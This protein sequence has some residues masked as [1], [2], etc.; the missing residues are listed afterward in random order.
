L[1]LPLAL[2]LV[3]QRQEIRKK[4]KGIRKELVLFLD[5]QSNSQKDP[6]RSGQ[7]QIK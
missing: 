5:P 4:A 1:I 2:F 6:W 3:R 7:E